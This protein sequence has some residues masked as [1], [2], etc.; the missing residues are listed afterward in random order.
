[1]RLFAPLKE[2]NRCGKGRTISV[3]SGGSS[4]AAGEQR[5][6]QQDIDHLS[7]K[8]VGI[9]KDFAPKDR[10]FYLQV[11]T[12]EPHLPYFYPKRYADK[13]ASEEAYLSAYLLG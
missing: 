5:A 13:Y 6:D 9:V 10:P 8:A 11:S 4:N 3:G 2:S 12:T 7:E 1:M